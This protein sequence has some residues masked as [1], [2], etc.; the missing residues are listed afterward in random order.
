MERSTSSPKTQ[1]LSLINLF[2]SA[3]ASDHLRSARRLLEKATGS[4][5]YLRLLSFNQLQPEHFPSALMARGS[6]RKS[7]IE[8]PFA[9]TPNQQR[10]TSC[11]MRDDR[12]FVDDHDRIRPW[13]LSKLQLLFSF[14]F[15]SCFATSNPL[16]TSAV[17][18][19]Q[20]LSILLFLAPP[21]SPEGEMER[22]ARE[23][24]TALP[25]DEISSSLSSL[26]NTANRIPM[27]PSLHG[28]SSISIF[29][30]CVSS[31]LDISKV[32]IADH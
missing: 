23:I 5:L 22:D 26:F 21:G 1:H 6:D 24:I 20:L 17:S 2:N 3:L 10:L 11:L 28:S 31:H 8:N 19:L 16:W 7:P 15:D 30:R 14:P 9:N 4:L 13:I 18:S 32:E 25:P 12:I 29:A 27:P